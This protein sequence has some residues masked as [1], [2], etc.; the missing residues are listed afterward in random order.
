MIIF[1]KHIYPAVYEEKSALFVK[2]QLEISL[3]LWYIIKILQ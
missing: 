2:K 3:F 1:Q